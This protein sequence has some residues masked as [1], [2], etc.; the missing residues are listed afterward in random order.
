MEIVVDGSNLRSG[1]TVLTCAAENHASYYS[2]PEPDHGT[3]GTPGPSRAICPNN[4]DFP[5]SKG[6]AK[7]A[8]CDRRKKE[9]G[10]GIPQPGTNRWLESTLATIWIKEK[11]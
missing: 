10:I 7:A 6:V 9:L 2:S 11:W 5:R 1:K 3:H 8:D 4:I